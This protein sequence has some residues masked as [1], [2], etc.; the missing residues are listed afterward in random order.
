MGPTYTIHMEF[1]EPRYHPDQASINSAYGGKVNDAPEAMNQEIVLDYTGTTYSWGVNARQPHTFANKPI[2]RNPRWVC[3]THGTHSGMLGIDA[4]CRLTTLEFEFSA[5]K[6]WADDS[7]RYEFFL[8]GL[9]GVKSNKFIKNGGWSYVFENQSAYCSYRCSQ[10]IDWNL[11]GQ[12]QLLDNPNDLDLS[13]M[14]VEGVGGKQESLAELRSRMHLDEEDMNGRLMLVVENLD[15]S[16]SSAGELGDALSRASN[17]DVPASAIKGSSLYEIDFARI[18]R[19]TIVKTGQSLRLSVGFPEGFDASMA[20]IVF[21][22]Y[23]FTRN[24]D[25]AIISVEEIPVTVTPY[26]L[27]ILCDSFSPFEIVALDA[28]LIRETPG[29]G[30]TVM[31]VA[32]EGGS[33][34]LANGTAATGKNGVVTLTQGQSVTLKVQLGDGK[35]VDAVL[36]DGREIPV[37]ADGTVVVTYAD[38]QS[39]AC[40]LRASFISAAVRQA[41]EAAGMTPVIPAAGGPDNPN[42]GGSTMIPSYGTAYASTQMVEIDGRKARFE[43][44]ALKDADGN[45]TNYVKVRDLAL[46]LNG[47]AAQFSVDWDGAVNLT[48]GRPY[49]SNGSENFTPFSGNR[50]YTTPANPTYVNAAASDLIAIVLTDDEGGGY[51]YYQLRDLGRKLGF[52]VDWTGERGVFVETD[53]PYTGK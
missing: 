5:S 41:D 44:Y 17:V 25:G 19:N 6:M 9:V 35:T 12:P 2:P 28:N 20:G 50:S 24:D 47:T 36:L 33:V 27:V 31:I 16:R 11:W 7:V 46:A 34:L 51:T 37:S 43:M 1:T 26:G 30:K 38:V 40:F 4:A 22:A 13:R 29:T 8:T 21:K 39:S 3:E 53:K 49:V 18:C 45:P 48:A 15:N 10:G 23:H 32:E 42:D 14:V 52:N